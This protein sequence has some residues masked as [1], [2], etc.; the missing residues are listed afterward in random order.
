[1]IG[2]A[3]ALSPGN[4]LL[5][6]SGP[7]PIS[8]PSELPGLF[9]FYDGI[10]VTTGVGGVASWNDQAG[11][12]DLGNPTTG[13]RPQLVLADARMNGRD[14]IVPDG[15]D[16]RLLAQLAA[17]W[18][19]LHDGTGCTVYATY[20]CLSVTALRTILDTCGNSGAGVGLSIS[21][22]ATNQTVTVIVGS[23][24]SVVSYTTANGV[25]LNNVSRVISFSY[26]EGATPNEWELRVGKAATAAGN[27][28]SAPSAADPAAALSVGG[29]STSVGGQMNGVF[30]SIYFYKAV[31][32][33]LQKQQMESWLAA[34]DGV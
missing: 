7:P 34:R 24:S 11:A 13:H 30:G 4:Q 23:G 21:H 6:S 9:A 26:G 29:R 20:R 27:S 3:F 22:N 1:M 16:D 25:A 8:S 32:A 2:H 10:D 17:D 15:V 31:H 28:A 14:T 5:Q 33:T 18:K 12:L 19:F